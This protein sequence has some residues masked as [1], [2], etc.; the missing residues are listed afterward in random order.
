MNVLTAKSGLTSRR[1][2]LEYK[3]MKVMV[4]PEIEEKIC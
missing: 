2:W 3:H 4:L 1:T